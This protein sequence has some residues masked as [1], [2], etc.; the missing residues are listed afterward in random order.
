MRA[1]A[2][3]EAYGVSYSRC[4][5]YSEGGGRLTKRRAAPVA[6]LAQ[7]LRVGFTNFWKRTGTAR[8]WNGR[9]TRRDAISRTAAA[10][11]GREGSANVKIGEWG[12]GSRDL[13]GTEI[14]ISREKALKKFFK[15]GRE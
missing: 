8:D 7:L 11:T 15:C 9:E 2:C 10:A 1:W 3:C 6:Q 12:R 14:S 13:G 4:I 5:D